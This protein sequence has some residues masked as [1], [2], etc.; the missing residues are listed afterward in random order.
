[1]MWRITPDGHTVVLMAPPRLTWLGSLIVY[2]VVG[3][4]VA[5]LLASAAP[6]WPDF[7]VLAISLGVASWAT[8]WIEH[9]VASRTTNP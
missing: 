8:L 2:V 3:L 1:M 4:A 9:L 5:S 7:L 6:G